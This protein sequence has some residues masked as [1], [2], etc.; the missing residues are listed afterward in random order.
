MDKW[1]KFPLECKLD[2]TKSQHKQYEQKKYGRHHKL[3][4]LNKGSMFFK[5]VIELLVLVA[6]RAVFL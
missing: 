2:Q 6:T 3:F 1:L 5:H 4:N